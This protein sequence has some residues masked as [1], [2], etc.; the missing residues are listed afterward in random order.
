MLNDLMRTISEFSCVEKRRVAVVSGYIFFLSLIVKRHS[1]RAAGDVTGIHESRFCALLNDPETPEMSR[2]IL[3]R[4]ARRRLKRI[5]RRGKITFII[6]ATIKGRRSR[7]VEN[8][9]KHHNGSGFS[10]GHKFVNFTVFEGDEVLP[11]ASI[12]TFTKKYAREN[13]IKYRTEIEI[14]TEWIE[15]LAKEE[16]FSAAELRSAIFLLDSGYDAKCIQKAIRAL[17]ADFVMALKSS[18][19]INGAKVKELFRRTRRWLS[20][21]SIRLHVGSGKNKSRRNYSIRTAA[22]VNMKGFGL[23]TVVCSKAISR[24]GKPT[25]FLCTSQ[26]TMTGREVVEWYAKRWK[27]EIWHKEMKQNYGFIDCQSSRFTAVESHVNFCLT[28]YLL[29][30]ESGKEQLRIEE[31]VRIQELESM[32]MELTKYGGVPRL[33]AR[34]YAALAGIAA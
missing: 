33:K 25:K 26:L 27:I 30:R 13:K 34:I 23:V 4:A 18:R 11:L 3:N 10:L 7:H 24:K 15:N 28:A 14:V 29:Q 21:E 32:K 6:D 5:K 19:S 31:F 17:G 16:L 8:T 20:W 9:R 22:K 12:P 2:Q 1:Y